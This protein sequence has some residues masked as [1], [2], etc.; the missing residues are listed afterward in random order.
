MKIQ[1]KKLNS[2][3][4]IPQ[5][6]HAHDAGMDLYACESMVIKAGERGVVP[7]GIAMAIPSGYVGLIWDKSGMAAKFGLKTM[8]GVIDA[9]YRGEV[10]IVMHNLSSADYTVKAGEKIA[11]MLIQP[12][13]QMPLVEVES[14]DD[15]SRG[16]GGFGSTGL[17]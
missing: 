3:A 4:I 15:T 8:A 2:D 6:A 7:T 12:V 13:L 16:V 9:G 1:I 17:K 5:Y 14:L 10:K 11:Q